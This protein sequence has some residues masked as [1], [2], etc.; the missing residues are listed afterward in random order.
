[1]YHP[2]S[3]ADSIQLEFVEVFNS[4]PWPENIG[5]FQLAGAV[6][7]TFPAG[8]IL[9]AQAV[10]VVALDP[11][12]IRS[13]HGLTNVLGP[14]TGRLENHG[15]PLRL[16]N[17]SG[18]V[19]LEV[20][21][22]SNPPWPV[23]ADG[24]G[25]SLVLARPSWGEGNPQ[26]WAASDVVGG[27]PGSLENF[28]PEPL[29]EVMINEL[30]AHTTDPEPDFVELHNH[31]DQPADLSG[32][33]LTDDPTTNKFTFAAGVRLGPGGFLA[34]DQTQLGFQL[35]S[36]GETLYLINSNST[37]VLDTVRF[38]AQARGVAFGRAPDGSPRWSELSAPTPG[39]S[40]R[41]ALQRDIVINEIM[42][43][44]LSRSSDDQFVELHNRG[45]STVDL[46][47]W[48]FI[49]GIDFTIPTH[50]TL[51]PGGYLVVARNAA[52]LL[53]NY[54]NL[55]TSNLVG[56]FNGNLSGLGE[57]L[58]LA[59]PETIVTTNQV[60]TVT[61]LHY[62][63]VNELTYQT[64]GRWGQWAK[65]GGSSLELTD[66]RGDNRLADQWADS[67]ETGKAAWTTV[68]FTGRLDNGNAA[69]ANSLQVFLMG[70]GE[71]LLDDV[72]VMG[73]VGVNLLANP[74]FTTGLSP[75][76]PQGEHDTSF[77]QEAGGMN[78][79]QCL[80]VRA[81]GDGDPGAN[82]IRV[83]LTASLPLNTNATL[84][85]KVRWLRGHPEILLRVGG[86]YLEALGRLSVPPNLG[87]P[88]ARN[89]RA[90]ANAG[91]AIFDVR[92]E[93]V[94]PAANQPV[95]VT[96]RLHDPDGLAG[97]LVKYR[98]DP[99]TSNV[100]SVP[101]MDDGT[102]GDAV[103][104][105][106]LFSATVPGQPTGKMM[107]FHVQATDSAP[108]P[109]TRTFPSDAPARECLVRF[110]ESQPAGQF[111]A[112]HLWITQATL[113]RWT[114][115]LQ[116]SNAGLDA[117]FVNG[118]Q[119][120]IYN[121]GA[122]YAGSAYHASRYTSPTGVACDYRIAIPVDDP[123][124]GSDEA[125][126]VWPGLTG[127]D[128][129][130]FS[131]QQEQTAYWV[132]AMLGLPFNYQRYVHFY[133]N[134]LRRS[135]I[136]QDTQKPDAD[137]VR[138]WFPDEADGELF[139]MQ[140]WR[141]Y[142]AAV[143]NTTSIGAT[144]GNFTTTGGAK[145]TARYRWCWTPR[146][147]QGTVNNF[148]DLFAL[149][150]AVNSP[151]NTY[152]AA[153]EAVVDIE[154]WMRTFAAEH[155]VG[156]WDSY[157]YGNGQNMY[158]YRPTGGR[159]KMII[160]DLDVAISDVGDPPT[161]D[162]FKLTNPYFP[163]FNGDPAVV[164][165][166]YRHPKFARAYWRAV[167]DAVNGPLLSAN[168]N[169]LLDAKVAAF[170][171]SGIAAASPAGIKTFL[172][173]RRNYM[174]A[175]LATV[176]A[177][178]LVRTPAFFTAED[179]LVLLSGN[180][181]VEVRDLA[182]N[183]VPFPVTWTSV[184]SWTASVVINPGRNQL[185]VQGVDRLGHALDSARW[186]NTV[187]YV[188]AV[189]PPE[190]AVAVNEILYRPSVP[191]A[192]FV[193]LFNSGKN[194]AFDLSNWRMSGLDFRFPPGTIL[195]QSQYLVLAKD[196]GLFAATYGT[197][198][199][200]LGEFPGNLQT[201]G[202]TLTLLRPG[203]APGQERVVDRIKYE[204]APP[205]PAS[206]NGQGASLQLIDPAQDHNRVSNWS[207]RPRWRFFRYTGT[208]GANATL[209]TLFLD[210]AGEV[211]LDDV[212]LVAGSEAETGGNL[213]QNG[214]FET[215]LGG[216]WQVIGNHSSSQASTATAHS[217]T[218]SLRLIASGAGSASAAVAQT[219]A[220]VSPDGPYTLSFW[221]LQG[222]NAN[223]LNFGLTTAFRS[224]SPLSVR[225]ALFTPGAPNSSAAV[226]P[227][228]PPVWLNEVQPANLAGLADG[229]GHRE[230]W[231]ELFNAGSQALGLDGFYLTDDYANL[232]AWPFPS[233][234]T[235]ARDAFK[236]VWADG[237]AGETSA[238]E[239]HTRFRLNPLAG[240]VALVRL[241]DNAP[242]IVD[243]LNYSGVAADQSYGNA[244]DGQTLTRRLFFKATPGHSNASGAPAVTVFIS[245][246]MASNVDPGGY[247]NPVGGGYDDWFELYNPG[248]GPADL[249]GYSL[250]DDLA[251][252]F[253]F[254]IPAGYTLAPGGYLLVWA[255]AKPARNSANHP[256]LHVNFQ[257]GRSGE[258]IGL[259]AP[260]GTA[261]D[262]VIFGPQTD[263]VSQGRF[264]DRD[265]LPQFMTTPTPGA[266]NVLPGVPNP[267]VFTGIQ[268]LPNGELAL[269]W[270]TL[271]GKT[272]RLEYKND[273]NDPRWT[274]LGD[275]LAPGASL[276][277]VDSI[278]VAPQRFYRL[279]QLD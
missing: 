209:L 175:R 31:H 87:T 260:D 238:S 192:G 143:N 148:T 145:K 268:S 33:H 264:P 158:A 97:A 117:T 222:T 232:T 50:T 164:N 220:G 47:G 77:L 226:L 119:R 228:Y 203:P 103:A 155:I 134:G 182:I 107:A 118:S 69:P 52:H 121:V 71:C 161:S 88:G 177:P 89:S 114:T 160:W 110:G 258:A 6:R 125:I 51:A 202:E 137:L 240:S 2:P 195:T 188:G 48:R 251:D 263:N 57:R 250:T 91:P 124:L 169:P 76:T 241:A 180:A 41:A 149:V 259:F 108:Q 140:I 139:K 166:M 256:D 63:V 32:C 230:P 122:L 174:V 104:G 75:W 185:V 229:A 22:K 255:D 272:Y 8:T 73:P 208:P 207:D 183:G 165:R 231:V 15:E 276:T 204:A 25:H 127:G 86:N 14:F 93:P 249:A 132:G 167:Q 19:L 45:V 18:A 274:P 78:N 83:P 275:Y 171:A 133:V 99:D 11:A 38:R 254:L 21:Y 115:R 233:G 269:S 29:R 82:R 219:I 66:P 17:R 80:H 53:T 135:F 146:T 79:S 129:V 189:V 55:G 223:G 39:Q 74:S 128:S 34:L 224:V 35:S 212:W 173:Q 92:H 5:D 106:G 227:P 46:G 178:F 136:M 221:Y 10:L 270:R 54:S 90:A 112:Y 162:L 7:Y 67:D 235:L 181:P 49:A 147:T 101:L 13:I 4:Q 98:I 24:A 56:D 199:P 105:D 187:D 84:R 58:A 211:F 261:I 217:G 273:L 64:G 279:R 102:G 197:G 153:V 154:Q 216:S 265:S 257:L 61:N 190:G 184:T 70:A 266:P 234:A 152:T 36:A 85:A 123:L 262:T 245:E 244:P 159:W 163:E 191:G 253:Q 206:A 59:M 62:I 151:S 247:A 205:W 267:P 142:D 186:T 28:G 81:G 236:V 130:D 94:L 30:L 141:E 40:N 150:D 26:A 252:P 170:A 225:R 172:T 126:I 157:G 168:L 210:S 37:R 9:P 16:L 176:A 72:E 193:E 213:I 179:N 214:D 156:N 96:A 116:L 138:Q 271:R 12:S 277:I 237:A 60:G 194:F 109:A 23:A 242:Q 43:A 144:L 111:G 113:N 243:Y 218:T 100:P 248:P 120:A 95:L 1:M 198:I 278:G 131:A 3:R 201:N 215:S 42:Y 65:G 239:W 27:S 196:R 68:E 246:W 44:P 200:V 20:A